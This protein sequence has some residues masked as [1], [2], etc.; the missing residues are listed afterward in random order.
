MYVLDETVDV[1]QSVVL[2]QSFEIVCVQQRFAEVVGLGETVVSCFWDGLGTVNADVGG[3]GPNVASFED[4]VVTRL[5]RLVC[6]YALDGYA[7]S[8]SVTSSE[9]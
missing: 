1:E 5:P 7:H 8:E 3:M 9:D 2:R 6:P 4:G